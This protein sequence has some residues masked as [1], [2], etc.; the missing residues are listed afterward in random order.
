MKKIV[1]VF[2]FVGMISTA[3]FAQGEVETEKKERNER[4]SYECKF[5]GKET[6]ES[7]K[8]EK[9]ECWVEGSFCEKKDHSD[10]WGKGDDPIRVRCTNGFNLRTHDSAVKLG[11]ESLWINASQDEKLLTLFVEEF[12][13]EERHEDDFVRKAELMFS[14]KKGDAN[15]IGG[16]CSF[17][18]KCDSCDKLSLN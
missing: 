16:I 3:A 4:I 14:R 8:D 12:K 6:C 5:E 15:R 18:R 10:S 11:D 2:V 13:K 1:A 7:C 17:K 9:I